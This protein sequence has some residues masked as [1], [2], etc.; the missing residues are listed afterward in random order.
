MV[1]QGELSGIRTS[2]QPAVP[3]FHVFR[4]TDSLCHGL[5]IVFANPGTSHDVL[6]GQIVATYIGSMLDCEELDSEYLFPFWSTEE[7][8]SEL[9]GKVIRL[10]VVH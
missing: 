10:F 3:E 1:Y 7:N 5:I 2:S 4:E 8:F 9:D 6:Y